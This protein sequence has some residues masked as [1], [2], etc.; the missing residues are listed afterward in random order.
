V[1]L[2]AV[3][4]AA[5]ALVVPVGGA[6]AVSAT[7]G[8][9]LTGVNTYVDPVSGAFHIDGEV[10][11]TGPAVDS[12]A[13]VLDLVDAHGRVLD[14]ETA[15]TS[16][17]VLLHGD[18]SGFD[19]QISAKPAGFDHVVLSHF[20]GQPHLVTPSH[21]ITV[22][23]TQANPNPGPTTSQAMSG[24]VRNDE[25]YIIQLVKVVVTFYKSDG[26]LAW[27]A[28]TVASVT[29]PNLKP[30]GT[31]PWFVPEHEGYPSWATY[32][33]AVTANEDGAPLVAPIHLV[34][35][36]AVKP[37]AVLGATLSNLGHTPVAGQLPNPAYVPKLPPDFGRTQAAA[38]RITGAA[39]GKVT[40]VGGGTYNGP[41]DGSNGVAPI[42]FPILRTARDLLFALIAIVLAYLLVRVL[43]RRQRRSARAA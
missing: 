24:T 39:A 15:Y 30:G 11:N 40:P 29:D 19:D 28:N 41:Q 12:V 7:S 34:T 16:V 9:R 13:A 38:P 43:L 10:V 6:S 8:L 23:V 36:P 31:L 1:P 35:L 25:P 2:A 27:V 32:S 18:R 33:I 5:L 22:T 14:T 20:L 21:G 26:S 37:T 17:Q 42:D 3:V 4:T